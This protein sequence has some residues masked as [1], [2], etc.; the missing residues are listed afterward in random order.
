M[1]IGLNVFFAAYPFVLPREYQDMQSKLEDDPQSIA[2]VKNS[3]GARFVVAGNDAATTTLLD[4]NSGTTFVSVSTPSSG[5][6]GSLPATVEQ[7]CDHHANACSKCVLK[8]TENRNLRKR[9]QALEEQLC[10]AIGS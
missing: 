5:S 6:T 1:L 9:V 8:E 4:T 7:H 2:N 10:R 3:Q